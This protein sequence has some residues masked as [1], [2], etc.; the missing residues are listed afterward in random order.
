MIGLLRG[1]RNGMPYVRGLPEQKTKDQDFAA[2]ISE[3]GERETLKLLVLQKQVFPTVSPLA[4]A[5]PPR[6]AGA[7]AIPHHETTL[8]A[9][10]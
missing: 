1:H 4:P 2:R 8:P 6:G 10:G 3:M 5:L 9:V 7:L